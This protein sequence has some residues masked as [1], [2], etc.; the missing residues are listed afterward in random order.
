MKL[1]LAIIN[2]DDNLAVTSALTRENFM[3][4]QLSTTGGFLLTGNT[5]LLVGADDDTVGRVEEIIQKFSKARMTTPDATTDS[6]GKGLADGGIAPE[7]RVGGATV[8]VLNVDRI[9]KY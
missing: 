4:T 7:V 8:F 3:V 9:N 5:T 1:V 2:N 6:L